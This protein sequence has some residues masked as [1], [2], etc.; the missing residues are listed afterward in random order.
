[1]NKKENDQLAILNQFWVSNYNNLK[2]QIQDLE[3]W[4]ASLEGKIDRLEQ[5]LESLQ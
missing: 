2:K 3:Q 1:M 4:N 5:T